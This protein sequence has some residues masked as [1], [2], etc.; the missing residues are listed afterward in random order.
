MSK[1]PEKLQRILFKILPD[2]R[3]ETKYQGNFT[4]SEMIFALEL[5][6][7]SIM[8]KSMTMSGPGGIPGMPPFNPKD[9]T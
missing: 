3:L 6:K 8:N 5:L 2:G 4:P 9:L 1:T 7:L